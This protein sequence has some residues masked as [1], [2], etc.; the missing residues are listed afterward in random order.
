LGKT[1]A[2]YTDDVREFT[3]D[4]AAHNRL[5]RFTEEFTDDEIER[6]ITKALGRFNAYPPRIGDYTL[7]RFPD[8]S[9]M[10]DLAVTQ[11]LYMSG[12]QRTRNFFNYND[13]GMTI[14]DTERVS[15]YMQWIQ[16]F[17]GLTTRQMRELKQVINIE[18]ALDSWGGKGVGSDYGLRYTY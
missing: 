1:L 8:D 13:A 2:E 11:L 15:Q 12:L 17:D 5:L 6:A 16:T 7:E 9:L 18:N 10:V 14:S 4:L 3:R